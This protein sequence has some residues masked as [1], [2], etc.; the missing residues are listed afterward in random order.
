MT[1]YEIVKK[2]ADFDIENYCAAVDSKQIKNILLK[3]NLSEL[4]YLALLSD[5]ADCFLEDIAQSAWKKT[6]QMFGNA[7]QIFTPLYISNYC[8]NVCAYCS[9]SRQKE[10]SRRHLTFEEIELEA[11]NISKSGIR[12]ILVLT[13]ESRSK[14][15][16]EYIE[17]AVR[18]MTR[19]FSSVSIE[20][21]P[22]NG[23]EYGRLVDAGVDGL[24]IYQETYEPHL[25]DKLHK[26]G[27]KNNYAFRLETPER[28]CRQGMRMVTV[29]A[30]FG[31]Y[32]WRYEAFFTGLHAHYLQKNFPWMEVGVSFPRLRPLSGEFHSEYIISDQKMVK[33]LTALRNFLPSAG[34]T[35]STR[36]SPEF[37]DAI[38]PM[39]V[40]KMSAGVS[41]AVGGHTQ[42]PSTVQFEIADRRDVTTMKSD[43]LE[44]G[45]QPVMHDWNNRYIN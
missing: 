7:V 30:L 15:S 12:H 26:G 42:N 45:Y 18:I 1:F 34:I 16:P 19:Y 13:G 44:K 17:A 38:L 41:T 2:Y 4:D 11:K 27:P 21:Y 29:G 31:L 28:A 20:I 22:L 43:L 40:T 14:A 6:R 32:N 9:F 33:M 39:G 25:Y 3:N 37:R 8:D 5:S 23:E 24:T 10:I 35:I 36:E